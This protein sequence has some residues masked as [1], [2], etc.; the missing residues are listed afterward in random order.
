MYKVHKNIINTIY[1]NTTN[2]YKILYK[3]SA[4]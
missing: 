3:L 1:K 2:A 4:K